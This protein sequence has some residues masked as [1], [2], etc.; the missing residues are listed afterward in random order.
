MKRAISS[1]VESAD[2]PCR[3]S[4][5]EEG[6]FSAM[7]WD[8]PETRSMA[9]EGTYLATKFKTRKRQRKETK[10]HFDYFCLVENQL[11]HFQGFKQL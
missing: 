6:H 3:M 4:A 7:N 10:V 8:E 1:E 5:V 2:L 9:D 11:N